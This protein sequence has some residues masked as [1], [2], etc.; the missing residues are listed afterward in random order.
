MVRA[1][2]RVV[3]VLVV[4]L[5]VAAG[6][7][8]P[9]EGGHCVDLRQDVGHG[10]LLLHLGGLESRLLPEHEE[11]AAVV[12]CEQAHALAYPEIHPR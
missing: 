12:D 7:V 4:H 11:E 2:A 1:R 5:A 3:A 8:D 10:A 9:V 6:Y